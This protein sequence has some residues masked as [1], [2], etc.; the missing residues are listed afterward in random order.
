MSKTPA[1]IAC[2]FIFCTRLKVQPFQ[3][4]EE[5]EDYHND[6]HNDNGTQVIYLEAFF[7]LL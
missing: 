1:V 7:F 6:K 2:N 4:G 5:E 3:E